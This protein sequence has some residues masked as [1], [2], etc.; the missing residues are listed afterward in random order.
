M[1]SYAELMALIV[2]VGMG[3]Y[4]SYLRHELRKSNRAGAMLTMVL[5]DIT[6]NEVQIER[7]EDGI[8]VYKHNPDRET[9]T[10]KC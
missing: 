4:I 8:R 10:D 7:T 2:F 3:L 5:H 9:S 1:I 6:T